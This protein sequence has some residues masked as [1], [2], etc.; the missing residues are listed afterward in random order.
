MKKLLAMIVGLA[1]YSAVYALPVYNPDQPARLKYGVFTHGDNCWGFE[2]GFRGDYVFNRE[3]RYAQGYA[4]IADFQKDVCDYRISTNA[5]QV[6]LNLW[7]R[8]EL[9]GWVGAAQVEF[10]EQVRLDGSTAGGITDWLNIQGRTKEAVAFGVG[11]R[12]VLWKTARTAVGFDGQYARS[13]GKFQC[14]NINGVPVQQTTGVNLDPSRFSVTNKE[15]QLSLGISH[16]IC[17][18][19][20]YIAMKYSNFRGQFRSFSWTDPNVGT[21]NASSGLRSKNGFGFAA[22]VSLVDSTRMHATIEGR[23]V[24]E[25]ALTVAAD[26]RF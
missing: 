2:L 21:V 14:V 9:Y 25:R 5:G 18:F 23:F 11:A 12:A 8:V 20:P 22:G 1:A 3:L 16:R 17:W 4:N 24:D 26:F 7:R 6:T 13:H 15:W 10:E 19:I